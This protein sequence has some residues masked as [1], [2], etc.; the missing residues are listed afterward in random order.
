M[1]A[2]LHSRAWPYRL[3]RIGVLA[4]ELQVRE[5][6]E[7]PDL[8]AAFRLGLGQDR[9]ARDVPRAPVDRDTL[10]SRA[11][12]RRGQIRAG[13]LPVAEIGAAELHHQP[14]I[15]GEPGLDRRDHARARHGGHVETVADTAQSPEAQ[16]TA[17]PGLVEPTAAHRPVFGARGLGSCQAHQ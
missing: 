14:G 17:V 15:S 5:D 11:A 13:A 6:A 16:V 3:L 2:I 12:D 7:Q 4:A 1:N 9:P 10:V 8:D